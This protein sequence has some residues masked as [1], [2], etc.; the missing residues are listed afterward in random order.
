VAG[1]VLF[2]VVDAGGNDGAVLAGKRHARVDG[3]GED[4]SFERK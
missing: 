3:D 4:R 2:A 1:L